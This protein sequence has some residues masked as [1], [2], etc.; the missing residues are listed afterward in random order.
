MRVGTRTC[1]PFITECNGSFRWWAGQN[2]TTGK[3]GLFPITYC[4]EE[5]TITN[6]AK[7]SIVGGADKDLTEEEKLAEWRKK[8]HLSL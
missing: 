5:K 6:H 8:R 1:R 2:L 3:F 4:T 7:D